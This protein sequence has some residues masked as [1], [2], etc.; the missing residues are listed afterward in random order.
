MKTK[1]LSAVAAGVFLAM[2]GVASADEPMKLSAA[3][4]DAVTASGTGTATGQ[5]YAFGWFFAN[6]YNTSDVLVTFDPIDFLQGT[7]LVR[8]N[9]TTQA[10]S[11]ANAQ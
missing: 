4:L 8:S 5:A 11:E 3:Q 6:T 9:V 7:V 10:H 2:A 1:L